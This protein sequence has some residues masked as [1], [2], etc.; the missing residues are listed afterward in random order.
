MHALAFSLIDFDASQLENLLSSDLAIY[1]YIIGGYHIV[2]LFAILFKNKQKGFS[3]PLGSTLI[4]H[5]A[6][7]ALVIGM[8]IGRQYI[9][10]FSMIKFFIPGIAPFEAAWL[11]SGG[12]KQARSLIGAEPEEEKAPIVVSDANAD[13]YEEFLKLL[14]LNKRPYRRPGISL[15]EEFERWRADR[16]K[17]HGKGRVSNPS[18]PQWLTRA[19]SASPESQG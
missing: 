1:A 11:F 19:T 13:E 2:L 18:A 15:K 6:C 8:A 5:L 17:G 12:K 4:T 10:F 3:L 9:P 7:L 16:P 14:Y